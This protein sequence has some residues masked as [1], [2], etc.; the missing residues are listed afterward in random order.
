[1]KQKDLIEVVLGNYIW[2][3]P[4]G[5]RTR[6]TTGKVVD[7]DGDSITIV[8]DHDIEDMW[9]PSRAAIP[10]G[11]KFVVSRGSLY[12]IFDYYN[13]DIS[14]VEEALELA[15]EEML[16][17]ESRGHTFENKDAYIRYNEILQVAVDI[18]I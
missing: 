16:W 13:Y 9:A 10:Q 15:E 8:I 7:V 1:M 12:V 2:V 6:G 18:S 14:T 17:R 4:N 11:A 3:N 5:E